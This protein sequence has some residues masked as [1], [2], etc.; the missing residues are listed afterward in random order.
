MRTVE[1]RAV[2]LQANDYLEVPKRRRGQA[3]TIA[4]GFLG[5]GISLYSVLKS[6]FP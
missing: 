4:S 1:G 3:F 6:V 5:I 2:R